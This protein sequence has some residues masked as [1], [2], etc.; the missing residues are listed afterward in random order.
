MMKILLVILICINAGAYC[1]E[2]K[3]SF[4]DFPAPSERLNL[5]YLWDKYVINIQPYR[6]IENLLLYDLPDLELYK[7]EQLKEKIGE[8]NIEGITLNGEKL[9]DYGYDRKLERILNRTYFEVVKGRKITYRDC[10][11]SNSEDTNLVDLSFVKYKS[12]H[13]HIAE[14]K[15]SLAKGV[16]P[17]GYFTVNIIATEIKGNVARVETKAQ[18][19]F[20]FD[21]RKIEKFKMRIAPPMQEYLKAHPIGQDVIRDVEGLDKLPKERIMGDGEE[22]TSIERSIINFKKSKIIEASKQAI[23]FEEL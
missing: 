8:F 16:V 6:E 14:I 18:G 12:P 13:S 17:D 7:D 19:A 9:C 10:P 15:A 1:A 3:K 4:S 23:C 21:L 11:G 5:Y 22:L 2:E 20:Y